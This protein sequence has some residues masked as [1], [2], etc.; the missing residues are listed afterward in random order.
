MRE[1]L[2]QFR[3]VVE[4]GE[5]SDGPSPLFLLIDYAPGDVL[6]P[7]LGP[8][9]FFVLLG[10]VVEEIN[11]S[12]AFAHCPIR[13]P[14]QVV[15]YPQQVSHMEPCLLRSPSKT[16]VLVLRSLVA[17]RVALIFSLVVEGKDTPF[18]PTNS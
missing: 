10:A 14:S 9:L 1:G 2:G 5:E 3:Q 13:D 18:G 17:P 11:Q 16:T 15:L 12:S 6:T 7:V 4:K 8:P